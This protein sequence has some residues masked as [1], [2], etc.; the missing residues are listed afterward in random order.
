M[1]SVLEQQ[2][3]FLKYI[4]FPPQLSVDVSQV[5]SVAPLL[6]LQEIILTLNSRL[7]S[8]AQS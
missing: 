5:I 2:W 7:T 1:V 4:V 6:S 8:E 3:I